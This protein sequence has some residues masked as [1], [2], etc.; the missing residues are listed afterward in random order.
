MAKTTV[1]LRTADGSTVSHVAES[2]PGGRH[3]IQHV[4]TALRT[5]LG[6]GFAAVT[7]VVG[8]PNIPT[9]A[10]HAFIT[11]ETGGGDLRWR[12]DGTSPA[13][14]PSTNANAGLLI[15]AGTA[16][17]IALADLTQVKVIAT[18]GTTT[19]VVEYA[20]LDA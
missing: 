11:V 9:G 13:A 18:T 19:I 16:A 17:E 20:K 10:T 1:G 2:L 4:A 6:Y 12:S 7:T 5:V 14:T 3:L 15:P 8:L